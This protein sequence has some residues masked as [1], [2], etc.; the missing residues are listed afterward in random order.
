ML[1]TTGPS[2]REL[3][4]KLSYTSLLL[5]QCVLHCMVN[6][7]TKFRRNLEDF[8]PNKLVNVRISC[9]ENSLRKN[10]DLALVIF[11]EGMCGGLGLSLALTDMS[12]SC[13]PQSLNLDLW[14]AEVGRAS[15]SHS[16]QVWQPE[17][18]TRIK[19][20]LILSLQKFPATQNIGSCWNC[21]LTSH[22]AAVM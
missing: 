18:Q 12:V 21:C 15:D 16:G 14:G 2:C 11:Y 1:S 22:Y 4:G 13:Q 19:T 8:T 17:T 10:M 7:D 6:I 20:F 5:Q 3:D 9:Q